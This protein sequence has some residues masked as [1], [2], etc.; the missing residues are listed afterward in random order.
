MNRRISP[1]HRVLG[2]GQ[3]IAR[4]VVINCVIRDLS[5]TGAKLGVSHKVRLPAEFHLLFVK[6]NLRLRVRLVR[7]EGDVVGVSFVDM[8]S[9]V[10]SLRR[11]L[12]EAGDDRTHAKSA[13]YTRS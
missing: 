1:R 3:I 4:G 11:A 9:A 10:Q 6:R 2:H 8:E 5:D 7:R 13:G 12:A